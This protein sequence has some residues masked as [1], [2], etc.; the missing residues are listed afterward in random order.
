MNS[1]WIMAIEA[2]RK[3]IFSIFFNLILYLYTTYEYAIRVIDSI[4]KEI[5]SNLIKPFS[6]LII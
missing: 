4:M 1:G 5:D 3:S 2:A 6:P